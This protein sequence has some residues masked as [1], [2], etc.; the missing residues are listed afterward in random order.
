MDMQR[1]Y[2]SILCKVEYRYLSIVTM[3]IHK[4]PKYTIMSTPQQQYFIVHIKTNTSKASL[5][6]LLPLY[7]HHAN[8]KLARYLLDLLHEMT[9]RLQHIL[10][11]QEQLSTLSW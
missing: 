10:E 4:L 5:V 7:H 8:I 2:I 9:I 3:P 11:W 6:Q 1:I